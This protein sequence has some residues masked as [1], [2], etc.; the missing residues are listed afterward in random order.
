VKKDIHFLDRSSFD[1]EAYRKLFKDANISGMDAYE[2]YTKIGHFLNRDILLFQKQNKTSGDTDCKSIQ[3]LESIR[4]KV[5]TS[6]IQ[7]KAEK[8]HAPWHI[9]HLDQVERT[10]E[11]IE[12]ASRDQKIVGWFISR[13]PVK[14]AIIKIGE[15]SRNFE[16]NITRHDVFG[17]HPDSVQKARCGFSCFFETIGTEA[18][19][20]EF[21]IQMDSGVKVLK[22]FRIRV[23]PSAEKFKTLAA[24]NFLQIQNLKSHLRINSSCSII[25]LDSDNGMHDKNRLLALTLA[26]VEEN[27]KHL[28]KTCGVTIF[29]SQE[30]LSKSAQKETHEQHRLFPLNFGPPLNQTASN[31]AWVIFLPLGDTLNDTC[32]L[33]VFSSKNDSFDYVYWD[34]LMIATGEVDCKLPGAPIFTEL[35]RKS[36]FFSFAVR[37]TL[38]RVHSPTLSNWSL[39]TKYIPLAGMLI[40]G[41]CKHIPETLSATQR[42]CKTSYPKLDEEDLIVRQLVLDELELTPNSPRPQIDRDGNLLFQSYDNDVC[43]SMVSIIIPTIAKLGR[44]FDCIQS[45]REKTKQVRYEI[46]ILDHLPDSPDNRATKE[47]LQA[48]ADIH[49]QIFGD[50]NWSRFNNIGASQASGELYLF[51]NDDVIIQDP[52]WIWR[53]LPYL[54]FARVGAIAP[55]LLTPDGC[56]QSS[57]VSI[58]NENGLAVNN[59]EFIDPNTNIDNFFAQSLRHV[60][61]LQGAAIL[62]RKDVYNRIGGFNEDLPLTFNDLFF[63]M[64]LGEMGYD[65]LINPKVNLIHFE[66]TSR[67]C[68]AENPREFVYDN[69][70]GINHIIGDRFIHPNKVFRNGLFKSSSEVNKKIWSTRILAT[71]NQIKK[72]LILRLDHIGDFA[73]SVPAFKRMREH[74]SRAETEI[75]LVC[76]EWNRELAESLGIF[77]KILTLNYYNEKSGDGRSNCS[78]IAIAELTSNFSFDLAID[79]RRDADTRDLLKSTNAK[80]KAGFSMQNHFPYLD[81]S[82]EAFT[83]II[84]FNS[85]SSMGEQVLSLAEKVINKIP[86]AFHYPVRA[87]NNSKRRIIIHPFSGNPIKLWPFQYWVQ[88]ILLL[89]HNG[90]VV[91]I[92]GGSSELELYSSEIPVLRAAGAHVTIG[93]QSLSNLL[94]S[95]KSYDCFVGLDS[96]PKHLAALA[97]IPSV[98]IQSG[99]VDPCTWAPTQDNA[100]VVVRET[101]CRVCYIDNVAFCGKSLSCMTGI[102][103]KFVYDCIEEL[104]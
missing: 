81:I 77:D 62:T 52:D 97:G 25:I 64:S 57:G 28:P 29:C 71:S 11:I 19:D 75:T 6:A 93:E 14:N 67:L 17:A 38:V 30:L 79:F 2:H 72:L 92:T 74:F 101:S 87:S 89:K 96:G 58:I 51:L 42:H 26:S 44:I 37:Q 3:S 24:S 5:T 53:L 4:N 43:E 12:L 21:E 1:E 86:H 78:L 91:D 7:S 50:F 39:L 56:I 69:K 34:E 15:I 84:G 16:L 55:Q 65:V 9:L 82:V 48:S 66:K 83:N 70:F 20:L 88:L 90:Y 33:R 102:T 98:S 99:F 68:L 100:I 10:G 41:R 31:N 49:I 36:H 8:H 104:I 32:L 63:C 95:F 103:P 80:L 85:N 73:L 22:S 54:S 47:R 27:Q 23:S 94:N 35:T 61:S 60:S 76:G 13:E 45:I 18:T 46:V 59:F 40:P